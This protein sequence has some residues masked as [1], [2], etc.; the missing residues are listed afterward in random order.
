M[1]ATI[2]AVIANLPNQVGRA[3]IGIL[4][5]S[6]LTWFYVSYYSLKQFRLLSWVLPLDG[7]WPSFV[8][9]LF[10]R[11]VRPTAKVF[12]TRS[13]FQWYQPRCDRLMDQTLCNRV[14]SADNRR[15]STRWYAHSSEVNSII[16]LAE[17][18]ARIPLDITYQSKESD[19]AI[20]NPTGTTNIVSLGGSYFNKLTQQPKID[21]LLKE[22]FG[23]SLEK[24]PE[25][26]C[27]RYTVR[28]KGQTLELKC[29]HVEDDKRGYKI[30]SDI[31]FV[32]RFRFDGYN[33][34]M[35]RGMHS[36]ATA[37]SL[38]LAMNP[39]FQKLLRKKRALEFIQFV[40]VQ[41]QDGLYF[42][43]EGGVEIEGDLM[44]TKARP[45]RL[46]TRLGRALSSLRQGPALADRFK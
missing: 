1:L 44:V 35:C 22:K 16:A 2:G 29:Y 24:N 11:N 28:R 33:V 32:C 27:E 45:Q 43:R 25:D 10:L 8:K 4:I 14:S 46:V 9:S 20:R 23:L 39:D 15:L 38:E 26:N 3:L 31:G 21:N 7:V 18:L 13:F 37:G 5:G 19:T 17:S 42:L 40:R 41:A 36:L 30:K 6:V 34:L 12:V